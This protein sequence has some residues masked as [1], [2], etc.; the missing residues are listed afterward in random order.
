MIQY[1]RFAELPVD[2]LD[3]AIRFYTDKLG[4]TVAQDSSY[5]D[6]WRWVELAIPGARTKLLLIPKRGESPSDKPALCL[7]VDDVT[8]TCAE[9]TAE[10]V[11]F[12]KPPTAAPWDRGE[13]FALLRD[14]EGNTILISSADSRAQSS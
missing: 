1:I 6:D 14:C 12:I 13:T 10:G 4:F 2:S 8:A 7:D 11:T 9:L 5:R 3:R